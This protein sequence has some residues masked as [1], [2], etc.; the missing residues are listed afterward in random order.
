RD[1][2]RA[3][4]AL[5]QRIAICLELLAARVAAGERAAL[6]ADVLVEERAGKAEGAVINGLTE[7]MLDF[8]GFFHSGRAF[9]RRLAH[10]VVPER[11]ERREKG[12]IERAFAARRGLHVLREAFPVPGDARGGH[13]EGARLGL[14]PGPP[15]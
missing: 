7:E 12:E 13:L 4:A 3:L 5:L 15:R 1:L 6:V 11:R 9:H 14:H 10:H 2:D 8:F